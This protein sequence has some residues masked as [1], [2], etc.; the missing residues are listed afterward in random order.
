MFISLL[1]HCVSLFLVYRVQTEHVSKFS[2]KIRKDRRD[3]HESMYS[4]P[5]TC[6]TADHT[7]A[8][9]RKPPAVLWAADNRFGD[10][11]GS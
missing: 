2:D 1:T 6:E 9:R 8:A 7:E 5:A 3:C 11:L 10:D 4:C